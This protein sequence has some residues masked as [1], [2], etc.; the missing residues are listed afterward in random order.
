[1]GVAHPSEGVG[2]RS[3]YAPSSVDSAAPFPR[4]IDHGSPLYRLPRLVEQTATRYV[5]TYDRLDGRDA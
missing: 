4:S 2:R 5:H 1:M 3:E